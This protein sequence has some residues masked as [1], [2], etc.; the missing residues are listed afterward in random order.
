[1]TVVDVNTDRIEM[2]DSSDERTLDM[3]FGWL[4]KMHVPEGIKTEIVGG[5]IFV[6]P[7]RDTHWDITFR[8][9]LQLDNCFPTA[10]QKS[11]VRIDYPGHLNGFASD[12]TLLADGAI[13]NDKGQWRYQDVEFVGDVISR[14]TAQNDYGPKK[15]AYA[16]AGVPVYLIAD[17]YQGRVYICTAPKNGEYT[18]ESKYSFG[19]DIDLTDTPVGLVLKTDRFPRD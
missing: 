9:L 6:S 4:D 12:V 7:Q 14:S 3:M 8:I 2:A 13:K 17:P 5:H 15:D 11:D 18:T 1:M 10:R 16:E 19:E